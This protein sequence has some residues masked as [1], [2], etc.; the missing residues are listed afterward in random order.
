MS[1]WAADEMETMDRII[2]IGL[3]LLLD[4]FFFNRHKSRQLL[5]RTSPT[6]GTLYL[7]LSFYLVN[8]LYGPL[9]C[10]HG[11]LEHDIFVLDSMI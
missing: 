5:A 8:A 3:M 4:V 11:H 6:C 1:T 10:Q 7:C 2:Q 9:T